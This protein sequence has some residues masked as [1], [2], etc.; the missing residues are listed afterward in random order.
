MSLADAYKT[1]GGH[2]RDLVSREMTRKSALG[3]TKFAGEALDTLSKVAGDYA[4]DQTDLLAGEKLVKSSGYD[5]YDATPGS[6]WNPKNWGGYTVENK[7]GQVLNAP[8]E[9][10][11]NLGALGRSAEFVGQDST[12]VTTAWE[13][14]Q[15][16]NDP[17]ASP[18]AKNKGGG[19][20][21]DRELPAK[22]IDYSMDEWG[23]ES[24]WGNWWD[25]NKPNLSKIDWSKLKGF[26]LMD[27]L[28]IKRNKDVKW[29]VGRDG[30]G[31]GN[32]GPVNI[33]N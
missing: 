27:I 6:N 13:K 20:E 24:K 32:R 26:N 8:K 10:I 3:A 33:S 12:K 5:V 14:L 25:K 18:V 19:W 30:K 31:S 2:K 1:L 23:K 29:W 15:Q 17:N 11:R 28:G 21:D 7:E 9:S 4:T 16:F 22:S